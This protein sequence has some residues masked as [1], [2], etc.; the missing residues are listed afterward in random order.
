V[1]DACEYVRRHCAAVAA[2]AQWVTIDLEAASY[3]SGTSGLDPQIH[4]LDATPEDV[5]RYVLVLEAINFGSGWFD[6][7]DV[8]DGV[9]FT[10]HATARLTAHARAH[11]GPWTAAQLRA[12]DAAQVAE[13]LGQ[14]ADHELMALY[15]QSLRQL[16]LWLGGRRALDAIESAAAGSAAH[17]SPP[18]T[19]SSPES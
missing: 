5:A 2:S 11:G 3:E 7:L 12:I 19:S 16:G 10:N 4:L 18:T 13:V 8:P 9:A 15:A 6:D 17:R 14:T 1:D